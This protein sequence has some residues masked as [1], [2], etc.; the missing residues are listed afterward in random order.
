MAD[1]D[2]VHELLAIVGLDGGP[3]EAP[4]VVHG[5]GRE[6]RHEKIAVHAESRTVSCRNCDA[7]LDP[8]DALLRFS[9]QFDHLVI[10]WQEAQ[11]KKGTELKRVEG[12]KKEASR[13][14][15]TIRRKMVAIVRD[16]GE[17]AE[18]ELL[19]KLRRA[20]ASHDY[21]ATRTVLAELARV[22]PVD[23]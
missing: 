10:W 18:L 14:Q 8:F 6:C 5:R 19:R 20:V 15:A 13:L 16:G 9:Q 1:E 4:I 11:R 22:A 2:H 21:H 17:W 12:L 3:R 7:V 23:Q